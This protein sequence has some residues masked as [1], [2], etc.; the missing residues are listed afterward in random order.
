MKTKIFRNEPETFHEH[1]RSL[2]ID[3]SLVDK[4]EVEVKLSR[5]YGKKCIKLKG[6][7]IDL[8]DVQTRSSQYSSEVVVEYIVV[9]EKEDKSVFEVVTKIKGKGIIKREILSFEWTGKYFA[10]KLNMDSRLNEILLRKFQEKEITH[11]RIGYV[12]KAHITKISTIY[13]GGKIKPLPSI[14]T[15]NAYDAIAKHIREQF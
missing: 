2:G 9:G 4:G 8:I 3:S 14:E 11:I 10:E 15:L 1:L 5:M 7:N 6:K 12:P 13:Q